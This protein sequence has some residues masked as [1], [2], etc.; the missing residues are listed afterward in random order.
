MSLLATGYEFSVGQHLRV[1]QRHERVAEH[2][3]DVDRYYAF[4]HE[5]QAVYHEA[6]PTPIQAPAATAEEPTYL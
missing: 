2:L 3:P 4:D 1:Q 5:A 6:C